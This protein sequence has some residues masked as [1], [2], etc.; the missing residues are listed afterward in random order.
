[1]TDHD[2]LISEVKRLRGMMEKDSIRTREHNILVEENRELRDRLAEVVNIYPEMEEIKNYKTTIERLRGSHDTMTVDCQIQGCR[3]KSC[4]E[5]L[6]KQEAEVERL[7]G[8]AQFPSWDV[9]RTWGRGEVCESC[10]HDLCT[11][12][13]KQDATIDTLREALEASCVC[14]AVEARKAAMIPTGT[15]EFCLACKALATE[16]PQ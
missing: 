12:I 10:S 3:E 16:A 15:W 14:G 2:W 9:R 11:R 5:L 1:V 4:H 7:R 13:R 6:D 8:E